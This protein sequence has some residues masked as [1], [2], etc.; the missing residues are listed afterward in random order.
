MPDH[1][2]VKTIA[3]FLGAK[4]LALRYRSTW[5]TSDCVSV[6]ACGMALSEKV[7]VRQVCFRW[8]IIPSVGGAEITSMISVLIMFR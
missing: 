2:L 1:K 3:R 8:A 6:L 5:S 4:R 7:Q